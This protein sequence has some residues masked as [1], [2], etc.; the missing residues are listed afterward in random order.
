MP[1]TPGREHA[2]FPSN[3]ETVADVDSFLDQRLR[4]AGFPDDLLA[5]IAVSVSEVVNNAVIHGNRQDPSRNVEID[6]EIGPDRV[7]I[8]VLDEGKGFDPD[9]LPNPVAQENLMREVGRGLFIVRAYMD[10][11]NFDMVSGR[12]LRITMVKI[13]PD[14]NQG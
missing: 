14:G 13:L 1:L 10:E 9:A 4:E 12:G 2:V 8:S 6:L 11:V 7:S 3:P 5:D